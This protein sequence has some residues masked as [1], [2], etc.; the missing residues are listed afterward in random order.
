MSAATVTEYRIGWLNDAGDWSPL[1]AYP[2]RTCAPDAERDG[3]EAVRLESARRGHHSPV[4]RALAAG[5]VAVR[6]RVVT[7]GEWAAPVPCVCSELGAALGQRHA[8]CR[9]HD[10]ATGAVR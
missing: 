8:L 2:V 4:A 9:A 5:R 1:N 7:V 3:A 10:G 6:V